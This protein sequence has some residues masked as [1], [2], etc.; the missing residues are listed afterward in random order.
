MRSTTILLYL[1]LRLNIQRMELTDSRLLTRVLSSA[2][3][4]GYMTMVDISVLQQHGATW[5]AR[6]CNVFAMTAIS[7][8]IPALYLL[9]LSV[10]AAAQSQRPATSQTDPLI[11]PSSPQG[12][13]S[14]GTESTLSAR[15]LLRARAQALLSSEIAGRILEL[16]ITEGGRFALG[17]ILVRFDCSAYEAQLAA[18]K[19]SESAARRFLAQKRELMRLQSAGA[20]D[21]S[22]AEA[23]F[24]E[25][26]AQTTLHAVSV[27]RCI[28]KSPFPGA[29]VERRV[30]A[31]ESVTG[32]APL[33]DIV[34]D[35]AFE[36]RVL[37][38]SSWL[39]WLKPGQTFRFAVEE[40]GETLLGKVDAVGARVEAASQTV[41]V[42]GK[43]DERSPR[44]V[45]GMS[46]AA[47]FT[48]KRAEIPK[49]LGQ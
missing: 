15:G 16:P 10:P 17:T 30:N 5:C 40:T 2:T 7:G 25:A 49:R 26:Q 1:H 41:L 44:L 36:V 39:A 22:L 29:V 35:T 11:T 28:V 45:A 43:L 6:F 31:G 14:A 24:E 32:G 23:K 46:G 48:P 27:S 37:A 12:A 21:V 34:D 9:G 19:A 3:H 13:A 8:V 38:P 20:F 4:S 18:A 42:I 33:L 47:H